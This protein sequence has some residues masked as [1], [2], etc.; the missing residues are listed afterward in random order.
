[1]SG[2][3]ESVSVS[4]SWIL[5]YWIKNQYVPCACDKSVFVKHA[6]IFFT[7]PYSREGAKYCDQY[8]ACLSVCLSICP[9]AY[10]EN[11]TAELYQI[12]L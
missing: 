12:F 10:L 8:Y 4:A 5:A 2:E 3:S 7:S 9:L 6:E 1:M 11:H